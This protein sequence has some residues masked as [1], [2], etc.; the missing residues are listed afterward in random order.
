[1]YSAKSIGM[2]VVGANSDPRKYYGQ[3]YREVREV[4]ARVKDFS[5]CI[6]N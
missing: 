4:L 6:G 2:D 3:L 1:M 5:L